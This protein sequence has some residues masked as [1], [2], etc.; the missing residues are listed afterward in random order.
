VLVELAP[1][2]QSGNSPQ[3]AHHSDVVMM[4]EWVDIRSCGMVSEAIA[5]KSPVVEGM[6]S[7]DSSEGC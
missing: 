5:L 7:Q 3:T 2:L 1:S 6:P 4:Y